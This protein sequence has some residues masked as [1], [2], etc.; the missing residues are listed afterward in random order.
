LFE[1]FEFGDVDSSVSPS[2]G[3]NGGDEWVVGGDNCFSLLLASEM[4]ESMFDDVWETVGLKSSTE[5]LFGP[6]LNAS[7]SSPPTNSSENFHSNLPSSFFTGIYDDVIPVEHNL[8]SWKNGSDEILGNKSE[9]F[10]DEVVEAAGSAVRSTTGV[11]SSQVLCFCDGEDCF[12]VVE[13]TSDFGRWS[14]SNSVVWRISYNDEGITTQEIYD[15]ID[16]IIEMTLIVK[17]RV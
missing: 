1:S 10:G 16:V 13:T 5:E 2:P 9:S 4:M 8:V 14:T 17:R 7:S 11:E 6:N 12:L 3:E 15:H